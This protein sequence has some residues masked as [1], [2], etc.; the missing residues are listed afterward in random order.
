MKIVPLRVIL[1]SVV[2]SICAAA[3]L[4]QQPQAN[5]TD[6]SAPAS[7]PA[8]STPSAEL[9][10][11]RRGVQGQ[12]HA[13][14]EDLFSLAQQ[15]QDSNRLSEEEKKLLESIQ[16]KLRVQVASLT[17]QLEQLNE[18]LPDD[19]RIKVFQLRNMKAVEAERII[20]TLLG[21]RLRSI[22][23]DE[24]TNS[25]IASGEEA[26]LTAAFAL[27]TRLDVET[28][29]KNGSP[30]TAIARRAADIASRTNVPAMGPASL[31]F[32]FFFPVDI[33]DLTTKYEA[34]EQAATKLAKEIRDT[35]D[36]ASHNATRTQL[37][38][39]LREAVKQSFATRQK[40]HRAEAN[41]LFARVQS[42]HANLERRDNIADQIIDQRVKDLLN[43]D[44]VGRS[45]EAL[46]LRP[47]SRP[48]ARNA[49]ETQAADTSKMSE[50]LVPV[51]T[52]WINRQSSTIVWSVL[53]VRG[54]SVV[55]QSPKT[56]GFQSG[57]LV[58]EVHSG[59][60][61][62]QLKVGDI[63]IGLHIWKARNI[64]EL[65]W[66]SL[67][68]IGSGLVIMNPQERLTP[69]KAVVTIRRDGETLRLDV[70]LPPWSAAL[71]IDTT[72][73]P[74]TP[75]IA[76]TTIEVRAANDGMEPEDV[77]KI[78]NTLG[79]RV[80]AAKKEELNGDR[81]AGGAVVTEV[82]PGSPADGPAPLR[83][84]DVIVMAGPWE[85]TSPKRLAFILTQPFT[86]TTVIDGETKLVG[87]IIVQRGRSIVENGMEFPLGSLPSH[88]TIAPEPTAAPV[89]GKTATLRSPSD[90]QQAIATA[91]ARFNRLNRED[92]SHFLGETA[93]ARTQ[94]KEKAVD[95]AEQRLRLARAEYAAQL[96]LLQLELQN[97]VSAVSI[98]EEQA[99][100]IKLKQEKTREVPREQ[101]LSAE[102]ALQDA[103][104]RE[105]RAKT[106]LDLY[107]Q[108]DP[109]QPGGPPVE[110]KEQ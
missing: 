81:Y 67:Q 37:Q 17:K 7:T 44:S 66:V 104:L 109:N 97:A 5:R 25:V 103:Q 55:A 49:E 52:S 100:M 16:A 70:D 74:T 42:I 28:A 13:A 47:P 46:G 73:L 56:A 31:A 54:Q 24:R 41:E 19:T 98:A 53:G 51:P 4:A 110:P 94:S 99:K 102:R 92:I 39:K 27:L 23:A 29:D 59:A 35:P 91:E 78:W 30:D 11:R 8:P 34:Q 63:I 85:V 18:R 69:E 86:L 106:L 65:A 88:R 61:N 80:R 89:D 32:D 50:Q 83:V 45:A 2:I 75:P 62:G 1:S 40:L 26:D 95:E 60:A 20:R 58:E 43:P 82:R 71:S 64:S 21:Q 6:P 101:V 3:L 14:E 68:P 90:F 77:V 38:D 84:G 36:D 9:E 107:Q 108:V 87:Q 105:Q 72:T 12:L 48:F 22:A 96:R 79:V 93:E 15:L 57:L 10:N 76:R 33:A